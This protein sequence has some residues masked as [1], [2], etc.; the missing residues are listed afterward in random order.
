VIFLASK[1][2]EK[3]SAK[4][5]IKVEAN[6]A[7][8]NAPL[9]MTPQQVVE[10]FEAERAKFNAVS[11]DLGM[12]SSVRRD[13]QASIDVLD[14]FIKSG[15][16]IQA[17]VPIGA[18]I[19][20]DAVIP[21]PKEVILGVPGNVFLKKTSEE[22]KKDLEKKAK[23]IENELSAMEAERQRISGNLENIGSAINHIKQQMARRQQKPKSTPI[24]G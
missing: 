24:I 2:K 1:K 8:E 10:L 23:A 15:K 12:T 3:N 14:E 13:L 21:N 7:Q 17:K 19:L 16:E 6:S 11:R 5:E 22:A 20:V 18:G 4:K 9:N